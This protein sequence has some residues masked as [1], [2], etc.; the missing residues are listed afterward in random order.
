MSQTVLSVA[1][2]RSARIPLLAPVAAPR[3]PALPSLTRRAGPSLTSG[4]IL[5]LLVLALL[6]QASFFVGLA[7]GQVAGPEPRAE[8]HA[9]TSAP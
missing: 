4:L 3:T 9:V 8:G 1:A 2:S 7:S 6:L 5:A